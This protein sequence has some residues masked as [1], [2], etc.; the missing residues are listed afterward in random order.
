MPYIGCLTWFFSSSSDCRRDF[1]EAFKRTYE[2]IDIAVMLVYPFSIMTPMC[3]ILWNV[4]ISKVLV[5]V[6]ELSLSSKFNF[7]KNWLQTLGIFCMMTLSFILIFVGI[8]LSVTENMKSYSVITFANLFIPLFIPPILT[9][10]YT[11]PSTMTIFSIMQ[12]MC[13]L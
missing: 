12:M 6:P 8:S 10:V 9:L 2:K 3:P 11:Y 13:L 7:P 1:L 5:S 4:M